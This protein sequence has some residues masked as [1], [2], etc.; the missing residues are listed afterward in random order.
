MDSR[1]PINRSTMP[2]FMN[3]LPETL[4]LMKRGGSTGKPILPPTGLAAAL[5]EDP[6]AEGDDEP[7]LLGDGD[8]AVR[9]N[10]AAFGV[11]PPHQ[12]LEPDDTTAREIDDGLVVHGE[13]VVLDAESEFGLEFEQS[14]RALV[15]VAIEDLVPGLAGGLGAVHGDIGV[16]HDLI[17]GCG[18]RWRCG[19][20]RWRR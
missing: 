5:L 13:V 8:E 1:M 7:G 19:R 20:C 2:R 18:S 17:G 3:S 14:H 4:T 11:H 9:R 10:N 12:A 15:H 16:A 6:P